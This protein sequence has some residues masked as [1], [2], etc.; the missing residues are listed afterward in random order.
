MKMTRNPVLSLSSSFSFP[1][2]LLPLSP[3]VS[4]VSQAKNRESCDACI[5]IVSLLPVSLS[6]PRLPLLCLSLPCLLFSLLSSLSRLT[7][8]YAGNH[9]SLFA[10]DIPELAS[11]SLSLANLCLSAL[12]LLLLSPVQERT[13]R[14]SLTHASISDRCSSSSSL[15]CTSL[16]LPLSLSFTGRRCGGDRREGET[17]EETRTAR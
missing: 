6:L 5:I 16:S 17:E 11:H 1:H 12:L 7:T 13:V 10:S 14:C 15:T 3:R 8:T 4:Q 9:C 2:S